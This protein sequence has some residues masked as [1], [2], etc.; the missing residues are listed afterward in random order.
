MPGGACRPHGGPGDV[1]KVGR[2]DTSCAQSRRV[3]GGEGRRGNRRAC[4]AP[5]EPGEPPGRPALSRGGHAAAP[6]GAVPILAVRK[7]RLGG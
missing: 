2:K 1:F 5:I 6:R 3:L 7:P 4:A